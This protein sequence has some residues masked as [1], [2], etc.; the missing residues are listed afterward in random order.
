MATLL[1]RWRLSSI[2]KLMNNKHAYR[3]FFLTLILCVIVNVRRSV[4]HVNRYNAVVRLIDNTALY[5]DQDV[6]TQQILHNETDAPVHD[7]CVFIIAYNR[8][9]N[10]RV[11]LNH[12]LSSFSDLTNQI[13]V[14]FGHKKY[15][16]DISEIGTASHYHTNITFVQD[17]I[18]NNQ[19]FT[20]RRFMTSAQYCT[21]DNILIIDDDIVPSRE[22]IIRV[23][24][25]YEK[26]KTQMYGFAPR[27]CT[28]RGYFTRTSKL[29]F[30]TSKYKYN[31]VLSN[32][33]LM[34]KN[35]MIQVTNEMFYNNIFKPFTHR[36]IMNK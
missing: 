9:N 35:I 31:L 15:Y 5:Q 26:D 7:M 29:G 16:I 19:Y 25:E 21:S 8:P 34:N 3:C 24:T 33:V 20:L 32:Y 12:I 11:L 14:G 17:W 28:E 18:K 2:S 23:Q 36:V 27:W 10:V 1:N 6:V 22:D 4:V 30:T 13:V